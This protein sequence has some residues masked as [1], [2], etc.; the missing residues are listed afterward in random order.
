M[1]AVDGV[2]AAD[3]EP[4]EQMPTDEEIRGILRAHGFR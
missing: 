1:L 2:L 4:L 3:N